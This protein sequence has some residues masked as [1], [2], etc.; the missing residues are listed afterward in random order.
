MI[1]NAYLLKWCFSPLEA[2]SEHVGPIP[3]LIGPDY[4]PNHEVRDEDLAQLSPARFQHINRYGKY[5]FDVEAAA[6]RQGL[7]PLRTRRGGA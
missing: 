4:E 3:F 6:R 2:V 5:R 1:T 7:R